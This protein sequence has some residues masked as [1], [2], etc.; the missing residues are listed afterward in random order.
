MTHRRSQW[1][2][3]RHINLLRLCVSGQGAALSVY[4]QRVFGCHRAHSHWSHY[5]SDIGT[6]LI[7]IDLL[8]LSRSKCLQMSWRQI[9]AR[10]SA[11]TMIW[12][13]DYIQSNIIISRYRF[14]V[15]AIKQ[16]L[17][18]IV[19]GVPG[20]NGLRTPLEQDNGDV[21]GTESFICKENMYEFFVKYHFGV[22]G[23]WLTLFN[24]GKLPESREAI[25]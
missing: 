14:F 12:W 1:K 4:Q 21:L 3:H 11:T 25:L 9:G 15:A 5:V 22:V 24:N 2:C 17:F 13:H 23:D 6:L 20:N 19:W 7:Y 16:T 8:T 10:P 18:K